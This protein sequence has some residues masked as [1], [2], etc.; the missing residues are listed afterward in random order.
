MPKYKI[1]SAKV[2]DLNTGEYKDI[3]EL[4]GVRAALIEEGGYIISPKQREY[5]SRFYRRREDATDFIWVKFQY[6]CPFYDNLSLN[7]VTR[8][9]CMATY[10][11]DKGF[12]MFKTDIG[13][14]LNINANLALNLRKELEEKGI[15]SFNKDRIYFSDSICYRGKL[16]GN[17]ADHIRLFT[18]A[19]Q[20]LYSS[21]R[22]TKHKYLAY[23]F[24][25]I[26]YMNRQTN[27]LS[28]NQQEQDISRIEPM[29]V[30]EFCQLVGYDTTHA[31]RF[32]GELSAFRIFDEPVVAFFND[33]TT[34]DFC[35]NGRY[36]VVNPK[37]FFGGDRSQSNYKI[38]RSLFQ[39]SKE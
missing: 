5:A 24:K 22:I 10:I 21:C 34:I 27:I 18:E 17:S 32:R 13:G 11:N 26:P 33:R 28:Y 35:S 39:K 7:N 1:A 38:I 6:N 37:L 14:T 31:G 3:S 2:I 9:L 8:M 16:Q 4:K 19:T 20:T 15:I 29:T 25:M 30:Q 12:S 23:I 36:I